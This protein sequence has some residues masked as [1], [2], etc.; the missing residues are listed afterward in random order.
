[1]ELPCITCKYGT[2][3]IEGIRSYH[4]CSDPERKKANFHEDT[5]FYRHTCDAYVKK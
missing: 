5:F 4:G 2:E 3:R 1:M